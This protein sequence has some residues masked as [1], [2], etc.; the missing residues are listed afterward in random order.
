M[1]GIG[2]PL[3]ERGEDLGYILGG[4]VRYVLG[5]EESGECVGG[6]VGCVMHGCVEGVMGGCV[7]GVMG[8]CVSWVTE[9]VEP[10]EIF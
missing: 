1:C 10:R 9:G 6:C 7:E 2:S 8:V 3:S 5:E 4:S